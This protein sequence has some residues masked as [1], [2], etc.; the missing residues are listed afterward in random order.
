MGP[1]RGM[2]T[3]IS[4]GKLSFAF[5]FS[6]LPLSFLVLVHHTISNF[7]DISSL[8]YRQQQNITSET[9][10]VCS[11]EKTI[12]MSL[13][14]VSR[15]VTARVPIVFTRSASSGVADKGKL[16]RPRHLLPPSL[17]PFPDTHNTLTSSLPPLQL[18]QDPPPS[19]PPPKSET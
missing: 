3:S 15:N 18:P 1:F 4:S 13:R 14:L 9:E 10:N 7:L 12:M 17:Q 16:S 2:G 8:L 11:A 6:S 5:S 19:P